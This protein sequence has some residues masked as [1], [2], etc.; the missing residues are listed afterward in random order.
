VPVSRRFLIAPSLSRLIRKEL[1][2]VQV[3]EGHFPPQFDRQSHVRIEN[4]E[5]HLVLTALDASPEDAEDRTHLPLAHAEALLRFCPGTVT[6]ARSVVPLSEVDVFVD[7][8]IIPTPLDLISVHFTTSIDATTFSAPIWFGTEVSEES[9]YIN[10]V[11]ALSGIP[12]T[13]E[14]EVSNQALEAVLDIVEGGVSYGAPVQVNR[15]HD[16]YDES[17]AATLDRLA[18]S[19]PA[20][21]ANGSELAHRGGGR[22]EYAKGDEEMASIVRN[23]SATLS[24]P[25]SAPNGSSGDMK[26]RRGWRPAGH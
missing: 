15:R 8:F 13:P 26:P 6:F 10:R 7:R 3:I 24:Q 16:S 1:G 14:T 22:N 25:T 19:V 4:G 12:A 17:S 2:S 11:I 21:L 5:A 9:A 18:D 23:L 20:A